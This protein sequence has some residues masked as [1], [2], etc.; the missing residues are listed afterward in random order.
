MPHPWSGSTNERALNDWSLTFVH[1]V[2][3]STLRMTE[4]PIPGPG[5]GQ[6]VKAHA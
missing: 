5:S 3:P 6:A 4:Q 1:V 2:P